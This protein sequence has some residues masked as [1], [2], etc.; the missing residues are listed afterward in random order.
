MRNINFSGSLSD[1]KKS[2]GMPTGKESPKPTY[3]EGFT[4]YPEGFTPFP[5]GFT[6]NASV[7][8]QQGTRVKAPRMLNEDPGNIRRM[9]DR[10]AMFSDIIHYSI[11][12]GFDALRVEAENKEMKVAHNIMRGRKNVGKGPNKGK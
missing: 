1:F 6:P 10:R 8:V 7:P 9:Q 2:I 5:P 11:T 3:P 12:N 4:P